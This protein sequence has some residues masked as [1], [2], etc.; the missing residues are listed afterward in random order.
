MGIVAESLVEER[1][2]QP[3]VHHVDP[4]AL[5]V[6]TIGGV[7]AQQR[8]EQIG[9]WIVRAA[10]ER[11]ILPDEHAGKGVVIGVAEAPVHVPVHEEPLSGRQRAIAELPRTLIWIASCAEDRRNRT[12]GQIVEI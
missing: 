10:N 1:R 2:R 7:I 9:A 8:L 3:M 4:E 12:A 6:L 5:E 11:E